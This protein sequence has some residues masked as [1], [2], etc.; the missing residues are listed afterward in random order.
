MSRESSF[1]CR[2]FPR[3]WSWLIALLGLPLLYFLM[4]QNHQ[5]PIENDL[6]AR[7]GGDLSKTEMGLAGLDV[8]VQGRDVLLNGRLPGEEERDLALKLAGDVD[9]VRRVDFLGALGPLAA[10]E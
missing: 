10:P 5:K 4:I 3:L 9:G 6:A 7:V 8:G 1:W 2:S